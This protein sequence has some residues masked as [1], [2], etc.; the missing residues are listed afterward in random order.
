[1]YKACLKTAQANK[2]LFDKNDEH[3]LMIDVSR[4]LFGIYYEIKE[5]KNIF[6]FTR[7]RCIHKN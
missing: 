1:M 5:L 7:Y 2:H 4:G 3:R 6:R